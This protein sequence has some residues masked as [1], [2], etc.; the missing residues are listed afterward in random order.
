MSMEVHLRKIHIFVQI[1]LFVGFILDF[2]TFRGSALGKVRICVGG[3][4]LDIEGTL[5]VD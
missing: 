4:A 2:F 3:I 1:A 5:G